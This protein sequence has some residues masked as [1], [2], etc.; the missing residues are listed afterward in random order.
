[1]SLLCSR[2]CASA[3]ATARTRA[4]CWPSAPFRAVSETPIA[5][6]R[7]EA[8]RPPYELWIAFAVSIIPHAL[9]LFVGG[10]GQIITNAPLAVV[11]TIVDAVAVVIAYF[12]FRDDSHASRSS[13]W[14]VWATIALGA[15]WLM[16]AVLV[17][18]VIL[19]GRVLCIS[20]SCRGPLG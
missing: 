7:A 19:L 13:H 17:G 5:T 11:V 12:Q 6:P 2:R 3:I 20:Q 16:Y 4:A 15:L 14:L 9:A 18:T 10:Y 1:M 8:V